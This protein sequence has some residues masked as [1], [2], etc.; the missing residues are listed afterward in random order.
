[1]VDKHQIPNTRSQINPNNEN[2]KFQTN[3]FGHLKLE[4]G[5][6]LEFGFWNLEFRRSVAS[7]LLM[8][9]EV[10]NSSS[11]VQNH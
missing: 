3:C 2:S 11:N 10:W 1:M 7:P 8:S 5:A 6:Y 9:E 4:F